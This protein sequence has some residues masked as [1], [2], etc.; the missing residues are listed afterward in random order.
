MLV[1]GMTCNVCLKEASYLIT[2]LLQAIALRGGLSEAAENKNFKLLALES[3]KE[4]S[5]YNI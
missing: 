3:Q 2:P 5:T 4:R 1:E